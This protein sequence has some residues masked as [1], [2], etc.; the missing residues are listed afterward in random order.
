MPLYQ[1]KIGASDG[2]VLAREFE[3]VSATVLRE[4]LEEQGFYVF[5]IHKKQWWRS[6]GNSFGGGGR[7]SGRDF[8][9]FNQELLVLLRSGLPILQ[10]LDA[11]TERMEP[12]LFREALRDI[13]EEIRGGAILSESFNKH[14]H[15]FPHL[16]IAS[17]K[18]GEKSGDL[19]VTLGRFIVYQKRVEAIRA[20]VKSAIF[21][22]ILLSLAVVTVVLFL[23]FYVIPS[24]SQIYSDANAVLPLATRILITLS[25]SLISALPLLIPLLIGLV[26]VLKAYLRSETGIRGKDRLFLRIPFLGKLVIDYAILGFC[27]T[28]GTTLLSGIPI[29]QAMSMARGTLNNRL[30]EDKMTIAIRRIEEGASISQ[31][32]SEG[33]FFP[34][35]A[36]RMIGVGESTGALAEMLWDIADYYESEVERRLDRLTTMVEP[37]MMMM[38]AI[39]IGGIV[40]AM[41]IPIFQLAG[42]VR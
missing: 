27:R 1:C 31:A 6:L 35:L 7:P 2:R 18:A 36:L 41:Y 32:I 29:V 34:G 4:S 26:F 14:S 5:D 15:L 9:T 37:L 3:A 12:G 33:N 16:Y 42:T 24:F 19:P 22:P 30:L 13:R 28:F 23:L 21:Y 38:M 11:V 17:I 20:K 40:I 10:V 39:V 25:N 8:L